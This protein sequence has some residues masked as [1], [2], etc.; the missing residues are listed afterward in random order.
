MVSLVVRGR[1]KFTLP[2]PGGRC[3]TVKHYP[4]FRRA[5]RTTWEYLYKNKS[6]LSPLPMS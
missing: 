3:M 6:I 1:G 2:K 5:T 4:D